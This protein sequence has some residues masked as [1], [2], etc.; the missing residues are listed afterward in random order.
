MGKDF[1]FGTV[2][3]TGG[4]GYLGRNVIRRLVSKGV[5]VRAIARSQQ[6]SKVIEELGAVPLKADL[7]DFEGLKAAA[8]GCSYG[9]HCAADVSTRPCDLE[10]SRKI[11]VEGTRLVMQA[12]RAAG[13]KRVVHIGTEAACV[14]FNGDPL[15]DV[16]ETTPLPEKPFPGTYCTTKN[17]AEKA[18]I[19]ECKDGLEVVVVRP[20]LIW[21]EDD[22]VVLPKL[23]E[24]A[25]SG[26]LK[27]FDGGEFRTSTCHVLNVCEGIEKAL[28]RGTPKKSYFL[29]DDCQPPTSKQFFTDMLLAYGADPPTASVPFK[30]VWVY[31]TLLESLFKDPQV[32]KNELVLIA[33]QV[34]VVDQLARR[35]LGYVGEMKME[36]GLSRLRN[37]H[38]TEPRPKWIPNEASTT[39][40]GCSTAFSFFLRRHHCRA[41]GGLFCANCT[42]SR[43]LKNLSYGN[44][45]QRVCTS[46]CSNMDG[47]SDKPA[48]SESK[49]AEAEAETVPEPRTIAE[50]AEQEEVTE[51]A[52]ASA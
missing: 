20:R 3:V 25:E 26:L 45:Q 52:D 41:C 23:A 4:S 29:T 24:A 27:W 49:P 18:A 40:Q 9:I 33:Q 51:T 38:S 13:V 15:I 17:E 42:K 6:S 8:E 32:T 36:E 47:K 12:C 7:E 30:A 35:E 14:N 37:R 1:D 11:N 28:M 39:C 34:T 10:H 50:D 21:G 2:F 16:D 44:K 19:S 22:T 46:C 5:P 48:A 43:T 31:A